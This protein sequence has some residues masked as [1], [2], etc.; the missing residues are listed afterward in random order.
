MATDA[1]RGLQHPAR[2]PL[3]LSFDDVVLPHLGA[4]YRLARWLTGN[5]PDAE[6]VVQEASL[7]ALRYFHTFSG[8]NGRA[9]FLR[10]VR[11]T[12]FGRPDRR[13][14]ANADPFDEELHS[15]TR[16][17]S[18]P[19]RLLLRIDDV[20]LV[21][22]AMRQVPDRYRE[23]LVLRELED[24]SYREMAEVMGIPLGTVMS[25]L[26][27]ARRAF[28]SALDEELQDPSRPSPARNRDATGAGTAARPK[29]LTRRNICHR[30]LEPS[31]RS[32]RCSRGRCCTPVTRDMTT[33][34]GC[35]TG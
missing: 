2:H 23:L 16:A 31:V 5:D 21:A 1:R 4:A 24:L 29:H 25:G 14:Q 28:R 11:H 6:D 10:I 34:A 22:Q 8:G 7:R 33:V 9:W 15:S 17:E 13:A 12:C 27:R 19:E 26:S 35:T 20:R 32:P 30:L 3:G 18:D